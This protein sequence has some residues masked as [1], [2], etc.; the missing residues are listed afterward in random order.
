M[1]PVLQHGRKNEELS[2]IELKEDEFC[3][4]QEEI[5]ESKHMKSTFTGL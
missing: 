4:Y 3:T 2:S 1:I 5:R